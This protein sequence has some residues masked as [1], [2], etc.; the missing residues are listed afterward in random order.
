[1][2]LS[3][4]YQFLALHYEVF[5]SFQAS[6]GLGHGASEL[7]YSTKYS[8]GLKSFLFFRLPCPSSLS[9]DHRVHR[10]CTS[11]ESLSQIRDMAIYLPQIS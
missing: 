11:A 8:G 6:R 2:G 9:S 4:R 7:E 10:K 1:M 5:R 3:S